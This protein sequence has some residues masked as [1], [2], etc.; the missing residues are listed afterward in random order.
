MHN[1]DREIT[2]QLDTLKEMFKEVTFNEICQF[3]LN[4][5]LEAIPWNDIDYPGVYLIEIKNNNE[6]KS[7][8]LWIEK[9]KLEWEDEKYFKKFTPNLKKIRIKEHN[10]LSNWIPIYIGKSKKIKNRIHGHIFSELHKTTFALKLLARENFKND[11]FRLSTIKVNVK[12]YDAMVPKIE[13]Q[14]RNK[15]NPLIGKQ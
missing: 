1:I 7:F 4:E 11:T 2:K 14:L 13:W 5:E 8:N 10:E 9:F 12:N 3:K 15:I 6:F